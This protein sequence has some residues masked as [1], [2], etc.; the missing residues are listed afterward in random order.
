MRVLKTRKDVLIISNPKEDNIFQF[1][2]PRGNYKAGKY[3]VLSL[4]SSYRVVCGVSL[5]I[6]P[7]LTC[8][9]VTLWSDS[10][11]FLVGEDQYGLDQPPPP[12]PSWLKYDSCA[13]TDQSS[14]GSQGSMGRVHNLWVSNLHVSN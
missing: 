8:D 2:S 1:C 4:V 12:P 10:P 9:V 13:P 7:S 14:P 11:T 5:Y 3:Y 6:I